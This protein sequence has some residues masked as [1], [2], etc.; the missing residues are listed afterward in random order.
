MN[1]TSVHPEK[2][3]T[4]LTITKL[5]PIRKLTVQN[6]KNQWQIRREILLVPLILAFNR[7]TRNSIKLDMAE[8]IQEWTK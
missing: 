1:D 3:C 7:K 2:K 4:I 8:S 5:D 6:N